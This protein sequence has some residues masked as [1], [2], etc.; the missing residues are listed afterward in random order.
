[1]QKI[2][3][4]TSK[5]FRK[6]NRV[7]SVNARLELCLNH[8]PAFWIDEDKNT[9]LNFRD[10]LFPV[11]SK[12]LVVTKGHSYLI[13]TAGKSGKYPLRQKNHFNLQF[14]PI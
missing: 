11:L 10:D 12:C 3:F 9:L 14:K 4:K 6:N 7:R 1:M 13:K 5:V 8:K 2:S